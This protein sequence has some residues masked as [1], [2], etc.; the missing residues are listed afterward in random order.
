[1]MSWKSTFLLSAFSSLVFSA[2]TPQQVMQRCDVSQVPLSIPSGANATA[3][4]APLSSGPTFIGAAIGTQNY[5]CNSGGTYTS[6]GAYAELFDISCL[7]SSS[8]S[9]V[10]DMMYSAWALA[11][12]S[13]NTTDVLQSLALLGPLNVLGQHYFINGS[14][15][16][17]QAKWDFTS[18]S[19][20]GQPNAFVVGAKTGDIPDPS[21]PATNVDWL[22]LNR[23]SGDLATQ[24]FRVDTR[25][26]QP[27]TTCVPG[28]PEIFV[29]Y[30]AQYIF[31]GGS[32]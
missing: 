20:N 6:A 10:T 17:L 2:P 9:M 12:S 16:A 29:K 25:G 31:Y 1:M 14:T 11:P 24:I 27:P 15:G 13:M 8:Y 22:S 4:A 32:F 30:A 19:Q 23:T 26:G 7:S 18:A 21:N 3:L 28:S 5:T